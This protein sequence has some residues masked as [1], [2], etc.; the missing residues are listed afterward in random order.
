MTR[1]QAKITTIQHTEVIMN[2]ENKKLFLAFR[3]TV[4]VLI[5]IPIL[6]AFRHLVTQNVTLFYVFCFCLGIIFGFMGAIIEK[7]F[8]E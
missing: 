7:Y 6:V 8:Y 3:I 2:S 4:Q 5:C 1:L